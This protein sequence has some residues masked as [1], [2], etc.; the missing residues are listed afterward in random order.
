M[1]RIAL[2][3][4][5]A[6]AAGVL[7]AVC[8]PGLAVASPAPHSA[9][10][11][12]V[13]AA[14]NAAPGTHARPGARRRPTPATAPSATVPVSIPA[15]R[16][17]TPLV[18]AHYYIWF[19]PSSWNRAKKDYPLVGRYDSGDPRVIRTQIREAKAA[20]IDGFIV[21]WK[22]SD[23]LDTTLHTLVDIAARQHFKLAITYEG[24]DFQRNPLPPARIVADL[25]TFVREFAS[26]PV[27]DIYGR[28]LVVISGTPSMSVGAVR[29]ITR[30]FQ[31]SL[32]CLASETN[33]QGYER[34]APLVGG[35]LY[36]W[37]SVNPETN[38]GFAQ[39]LMEMAAA[40]RAHR[41]LWIAP[42]SPGFDARMV[43][44]TSVV[45]RRNGTTLREEWNAAL[46]SVPDAIGLI[47][48]NEFSEN[49]YIEPSRKY[50]TRYLRVLAELDGA[51]N[52]S[53]P[54]FDS[55]APAGT[56]SP[57]RGAMT[58]SVFVAAAIGSAV[59]AALRRRSARHAPGPG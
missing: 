35:E 25:H 6:A 5:I 48:W 32:L 31:K 19:T 46:Q 10:G 34:L 57:A 28:P 18:L 59:F 41:Q 36:Y 51:P 8:A 40:V 2:V 44:G 30:P 9:V 23:T 12:Q 58:L 14:S 53:L 42:V 37:S 20:G 55:S 38:P 50:G 27:F 52:P 11:A 1:N 17:G 33:V 15:A 22:S 49:T 16:P 56:A 45:P 54:D 13:S 47:S 26:N 7:A 21:S 3:S 43:G 4:R 29:E 39:K 24:L